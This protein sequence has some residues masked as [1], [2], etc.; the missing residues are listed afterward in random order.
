MLS[1][2]TSRRL[3]GPLRR[4]AISGV[5]KLYLYLAARLV[6]PSVVLAFQLIDDRYR[7]VLAIEPPELLPSR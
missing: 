6:K 5:A 4:K 1:V 7:P 2:P 3:L